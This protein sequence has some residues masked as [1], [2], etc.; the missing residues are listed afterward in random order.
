MNRIA[1]LAALAL[2]GCFTTR[3]NF[4]PQ[5]AATLAQGWD[6]RWQH[7]AIFGLVEVSR[8]VPLS[9]ICP[10][11]VAYAEQ[12]TTFANGVVQSLTRNWYGPQSVWV[13]CVDPERAPGDGQASLRED[14]P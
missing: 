9:R 5:A 1:I 6:G 12:E 7:G 3:V 2:S 13:W 4:N 8:P 11:G 10:A 14:R